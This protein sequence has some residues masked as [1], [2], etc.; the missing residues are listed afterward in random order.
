VRYFHEI[1]RWGELKKRKK[2]NPNRI[3]LLPF[4][5]PERSFLIFD[6]D[7]IDKAFK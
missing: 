3:A 5:N 7:K 2:G 4:C 1:S 6:R